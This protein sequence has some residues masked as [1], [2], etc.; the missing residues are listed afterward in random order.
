MTDIDTLS[1]TWSGIHGDDPGRARPPA[2]RHLPARRLAR[3]AAPV[4]RGGGARHRRG[5]RRR[6]RAGDRG[7]PRRRPRRLVVQLRLLARRR[8][9]ELIKVAAETAKRAKIAFLMLPGVGTKDDI[10]AAPGQR[11]PDLPDRHPLHRGRHLDPALRAGPRARAGDRR[12]PDD[13][14]HPAARG[15]GQAGPDHGRRRLPVRL[16]RRLGRRADPGADRRPGVGARRRDRRRRPGRLPRPREPRPRRRQHRDRRPRRRDP[17][18]RLGPPLRRRRR[19][20]AARGVRRRLRQA[21][22]DA[23]AST[24]CRSSTPPRTS[25]GRRCPRSASS[26]GWP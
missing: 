3:Q 7:D 2:H 15:A 8:E 23:P 20:H 24:S 13:G 5:A 6:R 25:S 26:T 4:H 14:P 19:Q 18:R 10:R 22:L 9:Q 12:L 11:R 16:R 17:D 1:R 21:R